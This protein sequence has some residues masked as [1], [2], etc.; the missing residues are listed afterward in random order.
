MIKKLALVCIAFP[1]LVFAQKNDSLT[2][3]NIQNPIFN[4]TSEFVKEKLMHYSPEELWES[5]YDG[6]HTQIEAGANLSKPDEYINSVRGASYLWNQYYYNDFP[7]SSLIKSG[8]AIHKPN[9]YKQNLNLHDYSLD[10]TFNT[11]SAQVKKNMISFR[12]TIGG[13]GERIPGANWFVNEVMSHSSAQDRKIKDFDVRRRTPFAAHFYQQQYF[14]K[15]LIRSRSITFDIGNRKHLNFDIDGIVN[16]FNEKY[17]HFLT[18]IEFRMQKTRLYDNIQLLASIK[19]RD[20]LNA[21]Y[22]YNENETGTENVMSV[23]LFGSKNN[24]IINHNFGINYSLRDQFMN[25]DTIYRNVIDQD[26]ESFEPYMPNAKTQEIQFISNGNYHLN[27]KLKLNWDVRQQFI[28]FKPGDNNAV[29]NSFSSQRP[30]DFNSAGTSPF[31]SLNTYAPTSEA[32]TAYMPTTKVNARYFTKK[33]DLLF[34]AQAGLHHSSMVSPNVSL[35]DLSFDFRA[36]LQWKIGN[37]SNMAF[38]FGKESFAYSFNQLQ[39]LESNYLSGNF[40]Y[41]KDNG[42]EKFS[43]DELGGVFN[44]TSRID[45]DKNLGMAKMFYLELPFV[46]QTKKHLFA[47]TPQFKTYRDT[48]A[49]NYKGGAE[50][51]GTY[52][53]NPNSPNYTEPIFHLTENPEYIVQNQSDDVVGE[54]TKDSWL[55]NQPFFAGTTAKYA[56]ENKKIYMSVSISA[57][58]VVGSG[59]LGNDLQTN[60]VGNLSLSTANPNTRLYRDGRLHPDRAFLVRY[61]FNKKVNERF[62]YSVLVKYKDGEPISTFLTKNVSNSNGENQIA[63]W[64]EKGPADNPFTG[65]FNKREDA[66]YSV[67]CRFNYKVPLKNNKKI[68]FMASVYNLLDFGLE[69]N[70]YTFRPYSSS[71]EVTW[72]NNNSR[73]A[74][75]IQNPRTIEIGASYHF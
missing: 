22:N 58:M 45:Y 37:S 2:F 11:D 51:Y 70:E 40:N 54:H 38:N 69:I 42:D 44:N 41:W 52:G 36:G 64:N 43:T 62:S 75:E 7:I 56:F 55:F 65:V 67:D 63:I 73:S 12:S 18:E 13:L 19:S 33:N 53:E 31:I 15:G 25:S 74:L 24:A 3:Q 21:E 8:S 30:D 48:W 68:E 5:Y 27:S 66:Y 6:L 9:L 50:A 26:G 60:S 61:L 72:Y 57:Y 59:A 29:W 32:F 28:G 4:T 14:Q 1:S 35:H 16:D 17:V 20:K 34:H 47:F 10:F 49:V 39:M 71:S 46:H 23:S